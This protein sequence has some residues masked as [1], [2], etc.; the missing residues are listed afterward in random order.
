MYSTISKE[1]F[2]RFLKSHLGP[3]L[4]SQGFRRSGHCFFR[5]P[6][7]LINVI[8]LPLVPANRAGS[9]KVS[10]VLANVVPFLHQI[11]INEPLPEQPEKALWAS[12]ENIGVL[13][14]KNQDGWWEITCEPDQA[15]TGFEMVTAIKGPGFDFFRSQATIQDLIE[16][17]DRN[18]IL[19]RRSAAHSKLICAILKSY[20]GETTKGEEMISQLIASHEHRGFRSL[21][22][23]ILSRLKISE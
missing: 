23:D 19:P 4:S 12:F 9:V 3:F 20:L 13:M 22:R 16:E 17:F 14:G 11:W 21:A 7:E 2:D 5:A 8:Y 1:A 15:E 10:V 6:H 18:G